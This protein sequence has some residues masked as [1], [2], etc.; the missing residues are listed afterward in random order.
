MP[1]S[2]WRTKTLRLSRLDFLGRSAS[3]MSYNSTGRGT[4]LFTIERV[5]GNRKWTSNCPTSILITP[6]DYGSYSQ[7][8]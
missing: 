7:R 3:Y 5:L 2:P 6:L 1:P 4:N 8:V